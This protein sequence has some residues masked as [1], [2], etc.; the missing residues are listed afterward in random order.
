M[1]ESVKQDKR[2]NAMTYLASLLAS[3]AIHT[4]IL[5]VLVA[6]PLVFCNS[7]YPV[8]PLTWLTNMPSLSIQPPAPPPS[9]SGKAGA[10]T[11]TIAMK[12]TISV[13][14]KIPFGV[15]DPSNLPI[16]VVADIYGAETG[17][18][19]SAISIQGPADGT[20]IA[21]LLRKSGPDMPA[22][23]PPERHDPVR[24]GGD[25][26]ASKLILRV[27]PV[28]PDLA[29]RVRV[30]GVVV[31]AAIID[32]EGNVSDLRVLSGHPLLT[33]A[34]VEAVSRWRYSPTILNGEP[35]PV[36]AVVTVVFRLR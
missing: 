30:S 34:A 1:F 35:V 20:P 28:Y 13:P 9:P 31:L 33:R 18:A 8:I 23:K 16:P 11:H 19:G 6:L 7:L 26:Q 17:I 12:P 27:D 5:C 4:A 22:P 14:A 25:I 3:L 15:P 36:S 21:N 29:R 10:K 32:E 24:V 2:L